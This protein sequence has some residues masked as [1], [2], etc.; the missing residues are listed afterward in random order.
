MFVHPVNRFNYIDILRQRCKIK[1]KQFIH[2]PYS[3]NYDDRTIS[4]VGNHFFKR[5]DDFY[6]DAYGYIRVHLWA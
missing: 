1:S 6:V 5:N 4:D 3:P 2:T